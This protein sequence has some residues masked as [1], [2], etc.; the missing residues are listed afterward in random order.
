MI[1]WLA[2][3]KAGIKFIHDGFLTVTKDLDLLQ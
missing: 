1:L 2:F 3:G